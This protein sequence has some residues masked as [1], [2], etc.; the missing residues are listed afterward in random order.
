MS[1]ETNDTL[2]GMEEDIIEK[3]RTKKVHYYLWGILALTRYF[4]GDNTNKKGLDRFI[5]L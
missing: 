3:T 4:F 1:G 5:I 2:I